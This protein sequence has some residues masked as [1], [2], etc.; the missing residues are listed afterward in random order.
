MAESAARVKYINP[1]GLDRPLGSNQVS[2]VQQW[3]FITGLRGTNE[4]GHI[5]ALDD[6]GSRR[7]R[8]AFRNLKSTLTSQGGYLQ[9]IVRLTMIVASTHYRTIANRILQENEFFGS[10]QIPPRT[11]LVSSLGDDDIF[12]ISAD[13]YLQFHDDVKP[14]KINKTGKTD[15][16]E[17]LERNEKNK[18]E[19]SKKL[20]PVVK[21]EHHETVSKRS[22]MPPSGNI[23]HKKVAIKS[24][25]ESIESV[26]FSDN[27]DDDDSIAESDD[28]DILNDSADD[29]CD[30]CQDELCDCGTKLSSYQP[31]PSNKVIKGEPIRQP[32]VV[33]IPKSESKMK[34]KPKHKHHH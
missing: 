16:L 33:V 25:V 34:S 20:E 30:H 1:T 12:E 23:G 15:T 27:D 5:I 10:G 29:S 28:S 6:D 24:P 9:D 4:S 19:R 13:A 31:K 22:S 26:E 17:K 11:I 14:E 8:Q 7:I 18:V 2:R 3:V 32:K 21:S